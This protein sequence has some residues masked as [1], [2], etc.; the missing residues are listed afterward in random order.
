MK[1]DPLVKPYP[2]TVDRYVKVAKR[3]GLD[4]I[5]VHIE[6]IGGTN[7]E[8]N[9]EVMERYDRREEGLKVFP[10]EEVYAKEGEVLAVG[11]DEHI[12][13]YESLENTLKEIK[14][15]GGASVITHP[16]NIGSGAGKE[17]IGELREYI[18]GIE[19]YNILMPSPILKLQ[20]RLCRKLDKTPVAYS[21]AHLPSHTGTAVME[22]EGETLEDVVEAIKTNNVKVNIKNDWVR[23]TL[24]FIEGATAEVARFLT[25]MSTWSGLKG[26]GRDIRVNLK[27]I[28]S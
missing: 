9:K 5:G 20:K 14:E 28:L 10:V 2:S 4:G 21:Y 15:Q 8:R 24:Y 3:R 1:V 6:R 19:V 13:H 12:P 16:F 23:K 11:I 18:D 7:F 25:W 22:V 27:D 26:I 17:A